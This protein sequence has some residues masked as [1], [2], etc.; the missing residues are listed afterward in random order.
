MFAITWKSLQK[1][2][3]Y[4]LWDF[5]PISNFILSIYVKAWKHVTPGLNPWRT[6]NSELILEKN[7]KN[8]WVKYEE[9]VFGF[10]R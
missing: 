7:C 9:N 4:S 8:S 6:M 10:L 5:F 2:N 3:I 1:R